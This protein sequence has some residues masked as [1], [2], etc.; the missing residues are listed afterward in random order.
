MP[1]HFHHDSVTGTNGANPYAGLLLDSSGNLYGTAESGGPGGAGTVFELPAPVA[2]SLVTK[3]S[4]TRGAEYVLSFGTSPPFPAG[5]L[6][7][8]FGVPGAVPTVDHPVSADRTLALAGS[9]DMA[10]TVVPAVGSAFELLDHEGNSAIGDI[11]AALTDGSKF[12]VKVGT[13]TI[14]SEDPRAS[15]SADGWSG[16]HRPAALQRY[17]HAVDELFVRWAQDALADGKA[18]PTELG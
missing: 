14:G 12:T 7:A 1:F 15:Y 10:S 11:I 8:G 3:G 18:V 5:T 16:S 4:F 13:I 9:L 2:S 6:V 17:E